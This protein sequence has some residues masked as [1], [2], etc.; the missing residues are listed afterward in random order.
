MTLR[1]SWSSQPRIIC[2]KRKGEVWGIPNTTGK[3]RQA[4]NVGTGAAIQSGCKVICRECMIVK[5]ACS[6]EDFLI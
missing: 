6:T 4:L 3:Y 2:M 1:A 5:G